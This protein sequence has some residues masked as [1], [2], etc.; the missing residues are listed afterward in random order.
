M[1]NSGM[2]VKFPKKNQSLDVDLPVIGPQTINLIYQA[3]LKGIAVSSKFT[4]IY[5]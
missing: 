5:K 4:M 3:N 2:L 1:T